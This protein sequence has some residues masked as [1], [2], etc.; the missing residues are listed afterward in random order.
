MFAQQRQSQI[1]TSQGAR[2]ERDCSPN[3]PGQAIVVGGIAA[4]MLAPRQD[5]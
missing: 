3:A 4:N 2:I 5:S 1:G